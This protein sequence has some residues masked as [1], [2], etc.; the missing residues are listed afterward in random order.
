MLDTT[1]ATWRPPCLCRRGSMA[2]CYS[3]GRNSHGLNS[4]GRDSHGL[5]SYGLNSYGLNSFGLHSHGLN[6]HGRNSHGLNSYG[7][8]SYGPNSCL[9]SAMSLPLS[10]DGNVLGAT[11]ASAY[12]VMA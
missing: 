11:L 1:G 3:H 12:I 2:T 4:Y 6:S 8:N 10:I 5:N 7:L 9:A